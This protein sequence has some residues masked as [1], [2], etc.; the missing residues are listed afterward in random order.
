MEEVARLQQAGATMGASWRQ[1]RWSHMGVK[2]PQTLG[3]EMLS[4]QRAL[5][6]RNE[7]LRQ[8]ASI[9]GHITGNIASRLKQELK[10][11]GQEA[12]SMQQ[13][14][15]NI[16]T[17]LADMTAF[18][19]ELSGLKAQVETQMSSGEVSTKNEETL[20]EL[21]IGKGFARFRRECSEAKDMHGHPRRQKSNHTLSMRRTVHA[22]TAVH[23][24]APPDQLPVKF[25]FGLQVR[26]TKHEETLKF[27]ND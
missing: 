13:K 2:K 22:P 25:D 14:C 8:A 16:K 19:R 1:A 4:E 27:G 11:Q 7:F 20:K 10:T 15:L 24:D 12:L 21:G 9:R 6:D 23:E 5:D 17:Y 3:E 18:R 26:I